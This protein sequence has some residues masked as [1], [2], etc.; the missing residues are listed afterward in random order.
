MKKSKIN[1][2][3][4]SEYFLNTLD[5]L[6]IASTVYQTTPFIRL[7]TY[8]YIYSNAHGHKNT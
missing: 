5:T 3:R 1:R 8:K 4:N 6:T 7:F 2:V